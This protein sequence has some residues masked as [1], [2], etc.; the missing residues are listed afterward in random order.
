MLCGAAVETLHTCVDYDVPDLAFNQ[1]NVA[2]VG[3]HEMMLGGQEQ[4]LLHLPRL[5]P[6]RIHLLPIA[7]PE[8][9]NVHLKEY[10]VKY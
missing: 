9:R 10:F 2:P 7:E 4:V 3:L 6:V 8:E 5:K 1:P